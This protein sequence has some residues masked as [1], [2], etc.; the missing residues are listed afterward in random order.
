[1][2]IA[3]A[4]D[5]IREGLKAVTS[6]DY[7]DG[8]A[9]TEASIIE[10]LERQEHQG[11]RATRVFQVL[12]GVVTEIGDFVGPGY[13][14]WQEVHIRF[15]YAMD[16]RNDDRFYDIQKMFGV[17]G[18][19][20]VEKLTR[21]PVGDWGDGG[22]CNLQFVDQTPLEANED[23]QGVHETV[24]TIRVLYI[25]AELTEAIRGVLLKRFGTYDQLRANLAALNCVG[26][27]H[28]LVND[29]TLERIAD[30]RWTGTKA[31]MVG[32]A[33]L[34]VV[35]DGATGTASY[36]TTASGN[37]RPKA[38]GSVTLT[39]GTGVVVAT[40]G[41]FFYAAQESATLDP[42]HVGTHTT[43]GIAQQA[44]QWVGQHLSEGE[45]PAAG[46]ADRVG[47]VISEATGAL[48]SVYLDNGTAWTALSTNGGITVYNT[49]SA[50]FGASASPGDVAELQ[51]TGGSRVGL[52]VYDGALSRWKPMPDT[53]FAVAAAAGELLS[54]WAGHYRLSL[55]TLGNAVV[56]QDATHGWSLATAPG[57]QA[58]LEIDMLSADID[59]SAIRKVCWSPRQKY[60]MNPSIGNRIL[61]GSGFARYNSGWQAGAFAGF[62][63]SSSSVRA[64]GPGSSQVF[65]FVA[66]PL[67]FAGTIYPI[68][69]DYQMCSES[70]QSEANLSWHVATQ[71]TTNTQGDGDDWESTRAVLGMDSGDTLRSITVTASTVI[72]D[73]M[74]SYLTSCALDLEAA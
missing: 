74:T 2:T 47:V 15:R 29:Q 61:A 21:P 40:A 24:I 48:Q 59:M 45:L 56:G 9:W 50:L 6:P 10:A 52:W 14:I 22:I 12:P 34:T 63:S 60:Q 11:N 58:F 36:T 37:I 73:A 31:V 35:G 30:Y 43:W 7:I 68:S 72:G 54:M 62:D 17:D 33:D 1:M 13:E 16:R 49:I 67:R 46:T 51:T 71:P 55:D 20:V 44:D 41:A 5:V 69:V 39:Y 23:V 28:R 26:L 8:T 3:D 66:T 27:L 65:S 32:D 57:G 25:L 4:I 18:G 64:E 19:R 70:G 53:E 42:L 38:G